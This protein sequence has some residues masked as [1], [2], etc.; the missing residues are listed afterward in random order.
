MPNAH[1][2]PRAKGGLGVEENIVTLCAQCHF[3][4]DQTT[5]RT[6]YGEAIKKY[7]Q[8]HYEDWSEDK[9]KF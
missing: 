2:L 6:G 1:Y 3:N 5:K 9:I 4:F 7:L 8:D